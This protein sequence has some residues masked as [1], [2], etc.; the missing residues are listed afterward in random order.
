M[1]GW[2]PKRDGAFQAHLQ[3]RVAA[4]THIDYTEAEA[5]LH[6]AGRRHG[7]CARMRFR[8]RASAE[9]QNLRIQ[10]RRASDPQERKILSKRIRQTHRREVRGWK[11]QRLDRYLHQSSQW[12]ALRDLD[13]IVHGRPHQAQPPPDEFAEMLETLFTGPAAEPEEPSI[14]SEDPFTL[15]EFMRGIERMRDNRSADE[16]GLVA[17]LLKNVPIEF[18]QVL[19][20]LYNQTLRTG[21]I[22]DSWRRTL[23]I[24]LAKTASARVVTDFRPIANLR[25][26]YK[27]FAYLLLGRIERILDDAQPEEQHGFRGDHRI[28]EH[29]LTANLVIEKTL[30]AQLPVWMLS[31]DLSKAFDRVAWPALWQALRAHGVSDHL[32]W[33]MQT[34]YEDQ[35]GQVRGEWGH[36]REFTI[37]GGV[38]QGCVLSPRLF[39]CALQWAMARWRIQA[40]PAGFDLHDGLPTL[41]DLRYADDILLFAPTRA[42]LSTLI[43]SLVTELAEVGLILNAS[44]T[45]VLTTEAQAAERIHT[46]NGHTFQ[47]VG[48]SDSHKWLGCMLATNSLIRHSLDLEYHVQA[49]NKAFYKNQWLLCDRRV[50]LESRLRVFSSLITSVASFAS[51]H[52]VLYAAD[53]HRL[54]VTF[55][56]LM[57]KVVGPPAHTDWSRPW[58]EIL[59]AWHERVRI[60]IS[61]AGVHTWSEV[62]LRQFWRLASYV[63]SLPAHRWLRRVLE[64]T[65]MGERSRGRPVNVWESKL[66]QYCRW[67]G[68][69]DWQ[70]LARNK[71]SWASRED[72]FVAFASHH[73]L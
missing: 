11:S 69:G 37:T 28:E 50:S 15:Q 30:G 6:E 19:L 13:T 20:A 22:P 2:Q 57:R 41:V 10:R 45:K 60:V 12:R 47:V 17:E 9:L 18:Q 53:L 49:A 61:A 34:M 64:W 27:L 24:M 55:R 16:C 65:P 54:D 43:D 56:R 51:G 26:L 1:R 3:S 72:D 40:G 42:A 39:C 4:P 31:L 71:S 33:I 66:V 46:P 73:A 35:V 58:H 70:T 44:K 36:S 14:L 52:R 63:V 23:F 8:F 59:H 48:Q 32:V 25:L 5:L 67:R 68:L 38:R 29:L 7:K 62:C 21:A